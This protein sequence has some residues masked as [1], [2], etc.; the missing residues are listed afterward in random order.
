MNRVLTCSEEEHGDCAVVLPV[1]AL[2]QG[3]E[4]DEEG[5]QGHGGACQQQHQRGN[6]PV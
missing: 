2:A 4:G 1:R 6:L 5:H 3:D